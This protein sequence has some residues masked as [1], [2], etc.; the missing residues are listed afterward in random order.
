MLEYFKK[1]LEEDAEKESSSDKGMNLEDRERVFNAYVSMFES[2]KELHRTQG[3]PQDLIDALL[4]LDKRVEA[5][6]PGVLEKIQSLQ[7]KVE[8]AL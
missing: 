5:M 4:N 8:T 2:F 1:L 7:R 3:V 6:E